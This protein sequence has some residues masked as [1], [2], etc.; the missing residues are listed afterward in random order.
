MTPPVL[1]DVLLGAAAAGEGPGNPASEQ[2]AARLGLPQVRGWCVVLV[3]GLGWHNLTERAEHAPFLHARLTADGGPEAQART[4]TA[5]LPSSTA[6]NL[7]YLGTAQPGGRTGMLGYTVRNPATA[8][9]LNLVSWNGGADPR[10]WQPEDTVFQQMAADGRTAASVGPWEF[11]D[12]GL[13]KAALRGAQYHP[14]Q[15][16]PARVEAALGLMR[17][18]GVDLVYLYWGEL[19][20]IGHSRGW[21]SPEWAAALSAL[22]TEMERLARRLPIGTGMLL[23]ADHGMIDIPPTDL[24]GMSGR[25]DAATHPDLAQGVDLIGGE[26][27]FAHVYTRDP[28]AVADRWREV[29]G[30]RARIYT[31]AQAIAAGLFGE[32][33]PRNEEI[34][35]DVLAV[36]QG[37][38]A[39]MDSSQQSPESMRLVGMHGSTSSAERQV[40]LVVVSD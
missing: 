22:D 13:T 1:G 24:A 15:S 26:P 10:Q 36:T 11:E 37:S 33:H 18:P 21:T 8:G 3:D 12:S 25:I 9:L 31:R 29:L 27:R 4:L 20:G 40:P 34:I 38:V 39:I 30:D 7:G 16:L 28:G 6:T 5:A 14:A 2:A 17:D 35:G 32:V 19:D 23:T